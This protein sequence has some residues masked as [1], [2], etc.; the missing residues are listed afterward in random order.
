[1]L[2]SHSPPA[3]PLPTPPLALILFVEKQ[4]ETMWEKTKFICVFLSS[5]VSLQIS[6]CIARVTKDDE[7]D[8][9]REERFV[10]VQ[11][12][13]LSFQTFKTLETQVEVLT[14]LLIIAA[15]QGFLQQ[16]YL[17]RIV[18]GSTL[19]YLYTISILDPTSV[20][21]KLEI[22]LKGENM[23]VLTNQIFPGTERKFQNDFLVRVALIL[24]HSVP[25]FIFSSSSE[26]FNS[27]LLDFVQY[28]KLIL[29]FQQKESIHISKIQCPMLENFHIWQAC[30]NRTSIMQIL[31]AL[32]FVNI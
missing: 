27:W 2:H 24:T 23:I 20:P 29:T 13:I 16:T 25:T 7:V 11:S 19:I 15:Y 30:L 17:D 3:L 28:H 1:M 32:S 4:L 12:L 5:S 6:F 21:F 22:H 18:V 10:I 31:P 9:A 26:S 8:E 14:N